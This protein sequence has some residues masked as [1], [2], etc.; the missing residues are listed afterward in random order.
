[1]AEINYCGKN[2]KATLNI[3]AF[4]CLHFKFSTVHFMNWLC[5]SVRVKETFW[6]QIFMVN[7]VTCGFSNTIVQHSLHLFL[8]KL[9]NLKSSFKCLFQYPNWS[10]LNTAG[11]GPMLKAYD[12]SVHLRRDFHFSMVPVFTCAFHNGLL[13]PLP[14]K[15]EV[16]L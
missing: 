4:R 2:I 16:P 7:P 10:K 12:Y 3:G 8:K 6:S 14:V 9:I 11:T 13:S 15:T 1:M 5:M